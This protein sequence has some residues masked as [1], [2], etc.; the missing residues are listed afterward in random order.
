[1][2]NCGSCD[3]TNENHN[4]LNRNTNE[5]Q[6]EQKKM[7]A[8]RAKYIILNSVNCFAIET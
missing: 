4:E 7:L 6:K 1:M 3:E 2:K 8:K 5:I